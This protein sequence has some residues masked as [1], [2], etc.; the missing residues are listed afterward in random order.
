[1]FD[2]EM[3]DYTTDEK[4]DL[5]EFSEEFDILYDDSTEY[6]LDIEYDA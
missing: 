4:L 6:D 3:I 5:L 2:Y 1:M